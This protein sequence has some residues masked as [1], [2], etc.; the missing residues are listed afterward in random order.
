[1]TGAHPP[2]SHPKQVMPPHYLWKIHAP[3]PLHLVRTQQIPVPPSAQHTLHMH[4]RLRQGQGQGQVRTHPTHSLPSL[5]VPPPSPLLNI[6]TLPKSLLIAASLC[7]TLIRRSKQRQRRFTQRQG[8][9]QLSRAH[10]DSCQRALRSRSLFKGPECSGA[11][12]PHALQTETE[13]HLAAQA[14]KLKT[15]TETKTTCYPSTHLELATQAI[16]N[17]LQVKLTHALNHCLASLI[18]TAVAE[19]GIFL[20]QLVQALCRGGCQ[21]RSSEAQLG[22]LANII[23]GMRLNCN[24]HSF[25]CFAVNAMQS[26]RSVSK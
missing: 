1:M 8:Q 26:C 9:R 6:A 2:P 12:A 15:E 14:N 25:N 22:C 17:D 5:P 10:L 11:A 4:L 23:Q 24:Q 7:P 18:I 19:R 21:N 20:G 16:H 13:I 3:L